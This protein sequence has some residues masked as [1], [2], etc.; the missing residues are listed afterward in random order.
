MDIPVLFHFIV[1]ASSSRSVCV[2]G[3]PCGQS[4]FHEIQSTFVPQNCQKI[5]LTLRK[6]LMGKTFDLDP[7]SDWQIHPSIPLPI[8]SPIKPSW[9]YVGMKPIWW[10][11]FPINVRPY[12]PT[13][14]NYIN[15][16]ITPS[17][18]TETNGTKFDYT[19]R[20]FRATVIRKV[21]SEL[22][23]KSKWCC[24][25]R[26]WVTWSRK[27]WRQCWT[28][29]WWCFMS[30]TL[31]LGTV[32]TTAVGTLASPEVQRGELSLLSSHTGVSLCLT[33]RTHHQLVIGSSIDWRNW[34]NV[35]TFICNYTSTH[36][37]CERR[38]SILQ[39]KFFVAA[40]CSRSLDW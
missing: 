17:K 9:R 14:N 16:P 36:T 20:T 1:P 35:S 2:V 39:Q 22:R 27:L 5:P 24:F 30:V 38:Y 11:Q 7:I 3:L 29:R 40:W 19:Y 31:K 18:S 15:I 32:M 12:S 28:E 25:C 26:N 8:D 33:G 21:A 10:R 6:S 34:F 37:H 23:W 4:I 13:E